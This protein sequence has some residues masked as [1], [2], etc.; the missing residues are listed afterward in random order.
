MTD[1]GICC[2]HLLSFFLVCVRRQNFVC[3]CRGQ[4]RVC[5]CIFY[6]SFVDEKGKKI[7]KNNTN[8]KAR[9][10]SLSPWNHIKIKKDPICMNMAV[11]C[12]RYRSLMCFGSFLKLYNISSMIDLINIR[13]WPFDTHK[14]LHT[15]NW[16]FSNFLFGM[17]RVSI[18]DR[19]S[20]V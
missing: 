20:H 3:I 10:L 11:W 8:T 18:L 15:H 12:I 9:N 14:Q 5:L 2:C 4:G 19:S 16:Y 1:L 13:F 7:G 6:I 17:L